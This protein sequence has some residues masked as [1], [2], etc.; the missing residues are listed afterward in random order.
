MHHV[1]AAAARLP[2]IPVLRGSAADHVS[3][4]PVSERPPLC[5]LESQTRRVSR[6]LNVT[7][8][9][10]FSASSEEG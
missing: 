2:R 7:D 6:I 4:F 9:L 8:W 5:L 1:R 3:A 10:T